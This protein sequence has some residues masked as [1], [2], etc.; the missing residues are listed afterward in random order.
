MNAGPLPRRSL[1]SRPCCATRCAGKRATR[2][3]GREE[4]TPTPTTCRLKSS[5]T[6]GAQK[7][8]PSVRASLVKSSDQHTLG[9]AGTGKGCF[10]RSGRRRFFRRSVAAPGPG[11]GATGARGRPPSRFCVAGG[12][13]RSP[14]PG[15]APPRFAR[16][17][18]PARR[19][20]RALPFCPRCSSRYGPGRRPGRPG[21]GPGPG[22]PAPGPLDGG[23]LT[24]FA[25]PLEW[26]G[27]PGATRRRVAGG[28]GFRPPSA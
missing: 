1:A 8:R 21:T 25:A 19:P 2:P 23:A 10:R 27:F 20:R 13:C 14:G 15:G 22:P 18:A 7:R 4:F 11:R 24:F 26:R 9:R 17:P 6:L 5:I 3:A 12:P 16:Q 28:A